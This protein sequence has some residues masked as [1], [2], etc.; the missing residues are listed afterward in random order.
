MPR[1]EIAPPRDPRDVNVASYNSV[2]G[3]TEMRGIRLL[4]SKFEIKP[5][6]VEI[7][8]SEWR[9]S[10]AYERG[11]VVIT[12]D[13]GR[14]YG[15]LQFEVVGRHGRKKVL[16]ASGQYLLTYHVQGECPQED[17]E[18]FIDRVGRVAAYPYFRSLVATLVSQ[19][20]LQMPPLPM[21]SLAPRTLGS[22]ADL[23]EIG[24]SEQ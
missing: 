4:G 19:A 8:S 15:I 23:A 22:A 10:V 6:A 7:D 20:G 1:K 14:L 13:S 17:G 9:K 3:R 12:P 11:D 21:I 5:E 2:V 18:V 16:H 24:P